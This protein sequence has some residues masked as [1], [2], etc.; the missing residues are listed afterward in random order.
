[1]PQKQYPIAEIFHS[2]Q[3]EGHYAGTLMAFVR[4]A[5]CTVGRPFSK[6][7]THNLGLQIYQERCTDWSNASFPCDTNYK[8][9]NRLTALEILREVGDVPRICVTGGEPLMHDLE[10]FLK[11]V[12][13]HKRIHIET[14]G[15]IDLIDIRNFCASAWICVSPKQAYLRSA[16]QEANEIKVLIGSTFDEKKF[17]DEFGEFLPTN[18]LWIQPV[19]DEH[20]F[21]KKNVDT[22]IT[23]QRKYPTL[24]LSLQLHKAIGVR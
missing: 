4:F 14:S 13:V 3:G 23:L 24:R 2:P 12:S 16:L 1:M 9:S 18:K 11:I 8:M 10:E 7:E 22:C 17:V 21:I 19:N 20:T 15:T 5:G 6:S